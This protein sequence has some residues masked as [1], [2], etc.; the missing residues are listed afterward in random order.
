MK[1]QRACTYIYVC[2][3]ARS[4]VRG[5]TGAR[6]GSTNIY[7]PEI[8]TSAPLTRPVPFKEIYFILGNQLSRA[9]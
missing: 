2:V 4:Y 3:Y 1:R 8:W 6:H 5:K 7:L 9:E